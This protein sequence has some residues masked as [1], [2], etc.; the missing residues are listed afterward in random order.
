VLPKILWDAG[1]MRDSLATLRK[2]RDGAGATMLYGHDP[3]QWEAIPR[4]PAAV[5]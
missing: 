5:L 4:A 2:L 3:E 1:V